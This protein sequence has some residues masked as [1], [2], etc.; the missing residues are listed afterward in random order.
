VVAFVTKVKVEV[1]NAKQIKP[2]NFENFD[3]KF[4]QKW[5]ENSNKNLNKK[6]KI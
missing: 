6:V 3:I 2:S 1:S 5:H 4:E